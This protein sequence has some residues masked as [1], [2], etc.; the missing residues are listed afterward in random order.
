[1]ARPKK[2]ETF[3]RKQYVRYPRVQS[4]I[5][6]KSGR[7]HQAF[8]DECDINKIVNY[9]MKHGIIPPQTP[10]EA[11]LDVSCYPSYQEA[12]NLVAQAE[13]AYAQLSPEQMEMFP[14]PMDYLEAVFEQSE[15][16]GTDTPLDVTVPTDTNSIQT[17]QKGGNKNAEQ[18]QNETSQESGGISSNGKSTPSH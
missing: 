18:V 8:K 3:V 6:P 5:N 14:T 4:R 2:I 10:P 12:K 1:M 16:V 7:T 9:F 13:Q 17:K 11:Y 15:D